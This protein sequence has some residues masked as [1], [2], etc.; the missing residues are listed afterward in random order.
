MK[1]AANTV[2]GTLG[3]TGTLHSSC[4]QPYYATAGAWVAA[5]ATHVIIGL[6]R[7][8]L[9]DVL[10]S[11]DFQCPISRLAPLLALCLIAPSL[12]RVAVGAAHVLV[13]SAL[14]VT[15]AAASSMLGMAFGGFGGDAGG[16]MG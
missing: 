12:K 10:H 5:A 4:C 3:S 7:P 9:S 15:M 11:C 16:G 2:S 6:H 1:V 13:R 8:R 14:D